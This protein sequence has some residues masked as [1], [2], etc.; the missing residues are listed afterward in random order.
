MH[1]RTT[2][3]LPRCTKVSHRHPVDEVSACPRHRRM[4]RIHVCCIGR[5]HHFFRTH[6]CRRDH[7]HTRSCACALR[8]GRS[9]AIAAPAL[10]RVRSRRRWCSGAPYAILAVSHGRSSDHRAPR[11]RSRCHHHR[12]SAH[13]TPRA[14]AYLWRLHASRGSSIESSPRDA[15]RKSPCH[16]LLT[17][18]ACPPVSISVCLC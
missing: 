11:R 13:S 1:I 15:R 17:H 12:P 9:I 4:A 8:A 6:D 18:N 2:V 14:A 16:A 7:T 10:P 3:A 5:P